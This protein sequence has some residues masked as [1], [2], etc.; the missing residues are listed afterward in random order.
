MLGDVSPQGLKV[1][2][3]GVVYPGR[4]HVDVVDIL[5]W[6]GRRDEPLDFSAS[7]R[8]VLVLLGTTPLVAFDSVEQPNALWVDG[9]R[10][11]VDLSTYALEP[12][13][14]TTHLVVYDAEHPRGQVLID[15]QDTVYQIEIRLV[16]EPGATPPPLFQ[17]VLEAP[18]DGGVYARQQGRWVLIPSV[19]DPRT[20]GETLS[21]LRVVY[22]LD[23]VVRYLDSQDAAHIELVSGV[24]LGAA[25][26]GSP[27]QVQR[28]GAIDDASWN[29]TPGVV[30]L[31]TNGTLTQAPPTQGFDLEVGVALSA[32]RLAVNPQSPIF[33]E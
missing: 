32:T 30:W 18:N 21:A 24:T 5:R 22:E 19:V 33:L 17:Y 11:Y 14:Y 1:V 20:A 8:L 31:G 16:G 27:V 29:W 4:D 2:S 9:N 10:V 26:N 28:S 15:D 13:T 7:T 25:E 6:N 23:E 3:S 12:A